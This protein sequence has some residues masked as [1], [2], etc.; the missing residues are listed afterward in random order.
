MIV[1]LIPMDDVRINLVVEEAS[2]VELG[3]VNHTKRITVRPLL[4]D[5]KRNRKS[6]G[7]SGQ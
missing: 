5:R 3:R 2:G 1:Y 4:F 6:V 7:Q